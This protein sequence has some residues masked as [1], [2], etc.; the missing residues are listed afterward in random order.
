MASQE[1]DSRALNFPEADQ[2]IIEDPLQRAR[3]SDE[4][5]PQDR[6]SFQLERFVLDSKRSVRVPCGA[7]QLMLA[8]KP[9][10]A[11]HIIIP[12]SRQR[13]SPRRDRPIVFAMGGPPNAGE[14]GASAAGV[15]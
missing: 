15:Y 6:K 3:N 9:R 13:D 8:P 4:S 12:G 11:S 5:A 7:Q 14:Q 1:V 10:A 2:S